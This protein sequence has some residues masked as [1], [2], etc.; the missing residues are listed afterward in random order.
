MAQISIIVPVYQVEN[1]VGQCIESIQAQTFRDFELILIDD[2][3]RDQSGKICDRYAK[4]DC[5]IQVVHTKNKGAAAARNT[6][7]DMANGSYIVFVDGDDYLQNNMLERLYE[8]I[9]GSSYDMVVCDFWNIHED[10]TKDFRLA[11]SEETVTGWDVLA[12][13]KNQRNYGVWTIVWNKI[14][15]GTLLK[16]MRFP[17]GRYFEDEFFSNKLYLKCGQIHIIPDALCIHR[18]L[19]SS[20]MNTQKM[21][22][23]LDLIDAL[24]QRIC[25]YLKFD[26][27]A[28][29]TYKILIYMLEPY[30]MCANASFKEESKERMKA[31]R[32]FIRKAARR[33]FATKLSTVKKCS[34]LLIGI[35]PKTTYQIAMIFRKQLEQYL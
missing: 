18:V 25:I 14:Y 7:L 16:K 28:E 31:D 32:R 1:Y 22:N 5:R 20:T 15:K 35:M 2:G 26:L 29:E 11:L 17:E 33:L 13:L 24:K 30:T 21:E 34:L 9:N 4:E 19:S 6:G 3:S 23:Y 8:T 27:P 10:H 12:H